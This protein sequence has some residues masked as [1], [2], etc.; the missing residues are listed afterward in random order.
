MIIFNKNYSR[1]MNFNLI[2]IDGVLVNKD[3]LS[4]KFTCDLSKCKGACC[5]LES[6]Y[7]APV[8]EEEIKRIDEILDIIWEDLPETSRWIIEKEGFYEIKGGELLLRSVENK[9]CVFVYRENGIAKCA[10]EKAFLEGKLD[11]RKPISCHLFPIRVTNF[12]GDVLRY[13]EYSEC[14]PA[15]ELGKKTNL[16]VGQFCKDALVRAYG[17]E[18]YDKLIKQGT[19]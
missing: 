8:T 14:A 13:E 16:S 10:I 19:T 18:W 15:L 1:K 5:T 6:E 9:D 3:I 2:E 12:G 11:F 4:V 7:G 17:E